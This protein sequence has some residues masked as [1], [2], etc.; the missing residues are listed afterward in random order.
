MATFLPGSG[1]ISIGDINGVFGRGND[2]NSYR[3][4]SYYTSSAGPYNF[5]SGA[6]SMSDFYGTGPSANFTF[7]FNNGNNFNVQAY[8]STTVSSSDIRINTDGSISLYTVTADS[9][10]LTGPTA[11]GTPSTG[12]VGSSYEFRVIISTVNIYEYHGSFVV[13]GTAYTGAATTS[14]YS[15]SSNQLMTCTSGYAYT[16]SF[17]TIEIRNTSTLTTI[18]R[19]YYMYAEGNVP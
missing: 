15:L 14:W 16:E 10:S 3:G 13:A 18:S 4:T 2:L 12:G 1:A 7:A 8:A 17:G 5:P 9:E 19:G 6:I 11:W